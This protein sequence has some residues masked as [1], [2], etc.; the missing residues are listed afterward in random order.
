MNSDLEKKIRSRKMI[1]PR[2]ASRAPVPPEVPKKYADDYIEGCLVLADSPKASAALSRRC[3]QHLIREE[4]KV[5]ERDLFQ[6]IQVVIDKALLPSYIL[7][8]IDAIRSVGNFAAHPIKSQSTGEIVEVEP[9][10]AE[11]NL[12]VLETMFEHMFVLPAANKRKRE[13]L[14]AK[15]KDAG[16]KPMQ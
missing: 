2:G 10:E 4:L 13:A 3:L 1:Y 8:S 15:L 12:D 11:W 9:N 5:K 7:D 6:E 16:K 14:D